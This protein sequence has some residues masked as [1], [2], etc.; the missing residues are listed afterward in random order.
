MIAAN[1]IHTHGTSFFK[2]H[3]IYFFLF[4]GAT[5]IVSKHVKQTINFYF[6]FHFY[7]NSHLEAVFFF[8]NER[9]SQV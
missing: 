9:D 4:T 7:S 8:F 2:L 3:K 5:K 6:T 1:F